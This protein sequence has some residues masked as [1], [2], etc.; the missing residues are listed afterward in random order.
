MSFRLANRAGQAV[1]L[2]GR[3][4]WALGTDLMDALARP[5]ELHDR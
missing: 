4:Y 5:H 3:D 2:E 1:L